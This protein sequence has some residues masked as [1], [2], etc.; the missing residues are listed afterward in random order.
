MTRYLNLESAMCRELEKLEEKYRNGSE[1]SEGDL[2]RV[3]LLA[4]S[5]KSLSRY[6]AAKES[7]EAQRMAYES[8]NQYYTPNTRYMGQ[9][10]GGQYQGY[11]PNDRRW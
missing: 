11:M 3:D 8:N 9:N 1:M 10:Q 5:L 4:H 7:E 2:R 6:L